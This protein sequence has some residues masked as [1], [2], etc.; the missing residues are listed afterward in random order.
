VTSRERIEVFHLIFLRALF[1]LLEDRA[2]VVLKGGANLRF[3][4]ASP[5]FSED[6]D[7]DVRVLARETLA[8]KVDGLQRPGTSFTRVL[9]AH[10]LA[11]VGWSAPKQTGD[12]QRWKVSVQEGARVPDATKVEFS[13]RGAGV[14]LTEAIPRPVLD[15]HGLA[16]PI[17]ATHYG[18]DAA[19]AQKVRA[20]LG[21]SVPQARDVFDLHLLLDRGARLPP[22]PGAER[23]AA[24]E[25]VLRFGADDFAAQVFAFLEPDERAVYDSPEAVEALQL[26]VASAL[27]DTP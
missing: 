5:R 18:L 6:L 15:R 3:Y 16:G 19:A 24:E 26:R 1:A 11:I 20:L 23:V 2:L 8:R 25:R 14:G 21:R 22:L 7:L 13:R 17:V 4:A 27:S 10:G 12:V 9:A